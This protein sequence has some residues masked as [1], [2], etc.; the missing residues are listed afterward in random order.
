MGLT[1]EREEDIQMSTQLISGVERDRGESSS[2]SA[3]VF[4]PAAVM[5]DA[6]CPEELF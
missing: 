2:E 1:G 4:F 3:G 5:S 6:C